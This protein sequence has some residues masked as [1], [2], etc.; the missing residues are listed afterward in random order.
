MRSIG[1][2]F[3][4]VVGVF[5]ALFSGLVLYR[6][7][8]C[9]REHAEALTDKQARMALEFD[10]AL[11]D[12]AA[13]SIRP[14]VAKLIGEDEFIVEAMSTSHIARSVFERVQAKFPEYVIKFPSD[15]P[16]NPIN[17]A[18]PEELKML[19]YFRE[20]PHQARWNGKL[21]L[22][23]SPYLAYVSAMR[24][25]A[26]CLRCH[27]RP[28]D[29]PQSLLDRYGSTGGFY[30][31][32]GDVAGM[33]LIAIPLDKVY[34]TVGDEAKTNLYWTAFGVVA[35]FALVLA[36]F[37]FLVTRRLTTLTSHFQDAAQRTGESPVASV[38]IPG[39]DEISV[40]ADS[41]NALAA[42][43]RALHESLEE[44]VQ[45]RTAQLQEA[46]R[47]LERAKVAAEAASRAKSDFL[48]NMSHEIRTPMN[49][50][51]GMT[52]LVLDTELTRSQREYL[53]VVQESGHALLAV[54][55]DI[56]DLSRIEAGKLE[57]ESIAFRLRDRVGDMMKSLGVRAQTK[58]VELACQIHPEVPDELC[59]DPVRL[60]QVIINLVGN[61]IKFTEQGEVVLEVRADAVTDGE[62]ILHFFVRDTGIGIPANKVGAVFDAFTQADSSMTR[63]YGGTGL[64]LT[65][66]ARL[67]ALMGGQI[68]VTSELG[69]GS[70][71]DFTAR[72]PRVS[73]SPAPRDF[74]PPVSL[75]GKPVLIVDDHATNRLIL[76]EMTRAWGMLPSSVSD[77]TTALHA[78]QEAQRAGSPYPLVLSDV[79]MPEVDGFGLALWIRQ[80]PSLAKTPVI[81][82]TSGARTDDPRR[83][84]ELGAV[85]LMKPV[86]QSELFNVIAALFGAGLPNASADLAARP[87]LEARLP[88]LR[89]LLAEDSVFN[90]KLAVSLLQKYGHTVVVANN[91][92]QAV[93]SLDS[94]EFDV[95]L[96]DLE[97][98]E[99]DGLEATAIIRAREQ[100]TG[101]HIPIVAMTAHAMKGDRERCLAAGMDEYVSKPIQTQQLFHILTSLLGTAQR[102]AK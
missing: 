13:E 53:N 44:R 95:I 31:R 61:A 84:D 29:C 76:A 4:I 58:G 48:A 101:R 36:A 8:S 70:T 102:P 3:T 78:L 86:K 33:D 81:L 66:S 35:T 27:G 19:Q 87:Q 77:A 90:Q 59:G 92:S 89:I 60:N 63:K 24:I 51:L 65:I 72:F 50:I 64:G 56:L 55:N 67:V 26:S 83:A 1:A 39:N 52:D 91:G 97:M 85:H 16:R 73:A 28:E 6:A 40:L 32:V 23:G 62:A 47:E 46:N 10:L 15:D 68:G 7:W 80:D 42:R 98:P 11:R 82:L 79:N 37:R 22:N 34:A 17:K 41:Y 75:Q 21:E 43:L 57:L 5:A 14:E 71:F 49:A 30:R 18:G 2:K 74:A 25:E 94:G 93:T 12:Y 38:S 54:I 20:H 88:P 96:M 99:M 45:Q 100:A 69:Q 9:A